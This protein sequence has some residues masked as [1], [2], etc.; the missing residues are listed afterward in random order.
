[1]G[2]NKSTTTVIGGPVASALRGSPN[3]IG[4]GL[5]EGRHFICTRGK[6]GEP[7]T[8]SDF[9]KQSVLERY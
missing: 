3:K 8:A 4:E 6:V 7:G 2:G 5:N 9:Y 1:M